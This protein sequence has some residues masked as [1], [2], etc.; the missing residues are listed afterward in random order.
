MSEVYFHNYELQDGVDYFLYIGELKN[1]GLNLFLKE[2]LIKATGRPWDFIAVVPDIFEQYNYD[3]VIAINP[4]AKEMFLTYGCNV[5]CRLSASKFM[6]AVSSSPHV[7][8]LAKELVA[9]Q[10]ELFIYM[11][12]S[13]PDMSLTDIPG[14][15]IL[16]PPSEVAW[17]LNN[18]VTQYG[19][20]RDKVP[21]V[22]HHVCQGMDDLTQT[23]DRLWSKWSDGIF[24]TCEYSAAGINSVVARSEADIRKKFG[25]YEATYLITRYMPHEYDPTVLGVVANEKDVYV[26]G[27]ADQNI[28]DQTR[29]VGSTYPSVLPE[30][31]I[32]RLTEYTRI[33]G[34]EMAKQGYRGIFGCDYLVDP[35]GRILFLEVNARKQGTTLEFCCTLER[36]LPPGSPLLPEL[37]YYAVT[38]NRFPP[39]TVE[40]S[41]RP[42]HIHWGTFNFKLVGEVHT[43]GYIPQ[44]THERDAFQRVATGKLKKEFLI[45]EHIGNDFVVAS[46]SFLGRIV[47]L[48]QDRAGVAQG[49]EQGRKMLALTIDDQLPS[50]R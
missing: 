31:T 20:F 18:K 41:A 16:G 8:S 33:V 26:A 47:A 10:G 25:D 9:R 24:V 15:Q 12:E 34:R 36:T 22:D 43:G 35:G 37:E 2:A 28:A 46:G 6:R 14:V 39:N 19:L 38:E 42:D 40:P 45:L 11:Y 50:V 48:G 29:F 49:L 44:S 3:N 32:A 21:L 5:S 1:Y 27:V 17:R 7:G 4:R 23:T 13:L 30:D